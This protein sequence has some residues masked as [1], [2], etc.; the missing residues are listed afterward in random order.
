MSKI[1]K[2]SFCLSL[3]GVMLASNSVA[4]PG[5]LSEV[6]L[7]LGTPVQ[8][9]I[10]FLMDDSGSMDWEVLLSDGA[11]LANDPDKRDEGNVDVTPSW[12]REY[13]EACVGYNTLAYDPSVI[14]TPWVGV[15]EGGTPY[16]NQPVDA[17][18][19]NPFY[20]DSRTTNLLAVDS[21]GYP[22]GYVPWVD[23]NNNGIYESG[24]C[25]TNSASLVRVVDMSPEQQTNYANWYSYYRKREYVMKRA[26]SEIITNNRYRAGLASLHNHNNIGTQ[27]EDMTVQTNK[28]ELLRQLFRIYSDNGTPLRRRLQRAGRYFEEGVSPGSSFFGSTPNHS[29]DDHVSRYSPILNADNGGS[30]QQNFTILLSDGFWNGDP[31][32]STIGNA[33]GDNNTSFDG[34]SY[35]DTN[36]QTL[37]DV[38]MYYYERDL[39]SSLANEVAIT[40]LDPNPAQHMVTYTVAFGINGSL[41]ENPP[42]RTDPFIWPEPEEND[43]S[44][45]DD[46]RHAAW[47]GRGEFLDASNPQELIAELNNAVQSIQDRIA[48]ASTVSLTSG[49]IS[50]STMVFQALYNSEDWSGDL[51]A[52]GFDSL[53]NLNT[54]P[55]W[56]ASDVLEDRIASLGH[57][58]RL[59]FTYNGI[60]GI[61]LNFPSDNY[62]LQLGA[63]PSD[64]LL[65]ANQI[66]DLLSNAPYEVDTEVDLEIEANEQFGASIVA[67][68]KGDDSNE[69]SG[70]TNFRQRLGEFLGDIIH[71]D[72]VYVGPPRARYPDDI[73]GTS[74]TQLYSTFAIANQ[75]R[76]GLVYVG[77]NDGMLHAFD[78]ETGEELFAYMPEMVFSTASGK[79]VHKLANQ[80]YGHV[81]YVDGD[82]S[83][84]DVY[85][86]KDGVE[87]SETWR[88]YLVGA[89][90]NGGK[91]IYVLDVTDPSEF[92]SADGELSEQD[93]ADIAQGLVVGEFTHEDLGYTYSK[94]QIAKM[95]NGRWAAIFGNGYNSN[96]GV[97]KLFILYLD[98]LDFDVL[99]TGEGSI[100]D[101]DCQNVDSDCNGLSTPTLVDINAD[102]I[103]DYVYAGDLHGNVWRFNLTA[104]TED[105]S[106]L[107]DSANVVNRV[108]Q[109]C[110]ELPCLTSSSAIVQDRRQPITGKLTI[111]SH[112]NRSATSTEP[113]ILI[114]FGTGQFIAEND[115]FNTD[116]QSFY[117]IWDKE[118]APTSQYFRD[119]LVEQT[120]TDDGEVRILSNNPVNYLPSGASAEWGWY[121]DMPTSGERVYETARLFGSNI[122]FIATTPNSMQCGS[123]GNSYLMAADY[124][125]GGAPRS[126]VFPD[127][128]D[129]TD[130]SIVA[131][132]NLGG[133]SSGITITQDGDILQTTD[134]VLNQNQANDGR[135]LRAGRKSWSIRR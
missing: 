11:R 57:E 116:V 16:A 58:S 131:G 37:A 47:N 84:T 99:S 83:V 66:E 42:N 98:D 135:E 93:I 17:A 82:I 94:P 120:I 79:G 56:R 87:N 26:L 51:L 61:E 130:P 6:P 4:A 68:L 67:F 36:S 23:A 54:S 12:H 134:S 122:F 70:G 49:T 95:H 8:P 40:T 7:N 91:G 86:A 115:N 48:S 81:S 55:T 109:A 9:N 5:V 50:S 32:S 65:N 64:S 112:P 80:T 46:M 24:E 119:Q 53:G 60:R 20:T 31:P 111:R 121:M 45:I 73:E 103:L 72:P 127:F 88:T 133:F 15:D 126:I 21:G 44:T 29:T 38:A 2:K 123:G 14:Y 18:K 33:D 19:R 85:V 108:F 76:Q 74:L 96:G 105:Y 27:I 128:D 34:A 106:T 41:T 107:P 75:D 1:T 3:L 101:A 30:C 110:S 132:I 117:G 118:M 90:R 124:L 129:D 89:L 92:S 10:L 125:T 43:P 13:R 52:Y 114:F 22:T 35:A 113:N 78:S 69:G 71:S 39:S 104:D 77:A 63:T 28:D 62:E 100:V 25:S 97:A 102:S 59:I